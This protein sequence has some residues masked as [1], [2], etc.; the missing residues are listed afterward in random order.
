MAVRI[1]STRRRLPAGVSIDG[2]QLGELPPHAP[3]PARGQVVEMLGRQAQLLGADY[4][5]GTPL[6]PSEATSIRQLCTALER[7]VG[8]QGY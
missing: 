7:V 6:T 2:P 4:A 5:K 3:D 1:R 8:T